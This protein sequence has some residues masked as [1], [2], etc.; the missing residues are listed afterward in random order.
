[1]RGGR[2]RP[3]RGALLLP[4]L[5]V[6]RDLGGEARP[7]DVYGRVADAL[8]VDGEARSERG[9]AADPGGRPRQTCLWERDVRWMRQTAVAKGLM[10]G[11]GHG[12][13]TLTGLG[14]GRLADARPGLVVT[15]F[16]TGLGRAL[17]ARLDAVA[18]AI[19][20]GTVDLLFTSPPYPWALKGYEGGGMGE[21]DWASFSLEALEAFAPKMSPTGSAMWNVAETYR[22]GIPVKGEHVSRL[23]VR[24]ADETRWRCLDT[25]SWFNPSRL[26]SP[27]EWVARRRIRLKPAVEQI[28][29]LSANPFAEADNRRV[30]QP[31]GPRMRAA[32]DKAGTGA[33]GGRGRR[34]SG[35]RVA[36]DGGFA[37]D[38]GGSIP[39]NL[40]TA[41][42]A[43]GGRAYYAGAR[44]EGLPLHPAVMPEAV[45]RRCILLA[46]RPGAL[47]VDPMAGSLTTAAAAE[48]LGRR[49]LCSDSSLAYV[50]GGRHRFPD[51]REDPAMAAMAGKA[52]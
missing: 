10:G 23:R 37:R 3:A 12:R 1:M 27:F 31:Y 38:N 19:E 8:G 47:V 26:P 33:G 22:P 52:P 28:L 16:E 15:V 42:A 9:R 51:R 20:D 39:P 44:S 24:L 50:A 29:W 46:T 17:W 34:P 32:L 18:A 14:R 5:E 2:R 7:A 45:A 48:A 35:H 30:L 21:E 11:A 4:L 36:A 40:I 43:G 25:I 6:L 49:W 41:G 13:W